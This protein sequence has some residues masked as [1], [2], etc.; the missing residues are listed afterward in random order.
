VSVIAWTCHS[1]GHTDEGLSVERYM[2]VANLH[3]CTVADQIRRA[4]RYMRARSAPGGPLE[5][6][7][8]WLADCARQADRMADPE[9]FEVCDEPVSVKWALAVA[10]ATPW[11][12]ATR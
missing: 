9:Q 5:L 7:A 11:T 1:C 12:E 10:Q 6:V 4:E 8:D 2:V 3:V